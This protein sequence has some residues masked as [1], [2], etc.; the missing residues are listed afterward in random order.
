MFLSIL[1][2]CKIW[3]RKNKTRVIFLNCKK[4]H[5]S[6]KWNCFCIIS[7]SIFQHSGYQES[8]ISTVTNGM[9][10]ILDCNLQIHKVQIP[11]CCL[12]L[13]SPLV[14]LEVVTLPMHQFCIGL[15]LFIESHALSSAFPWFISN[16][17]YS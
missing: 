9:V 12:N 8:V 14:A 6:V 11:I 3:K 13:K 2:M 5:G 7:I 10:G 17:C 1:W 16:F 4:D 15:I